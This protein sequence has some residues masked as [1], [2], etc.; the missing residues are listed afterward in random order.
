MRTTIVIDD[1]LLAKAFAL[2]GARTKRELIERALR[3]FVERHKKRDLMDLFG[4]GGLREDYDYK[5]LRARM[6]GSA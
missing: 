1:D 5:A 4:T 2:S 3:E 6:P